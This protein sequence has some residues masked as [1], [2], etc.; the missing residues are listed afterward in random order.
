MI[1]FNDGFQ[2]FW[3]K[4]KTMHFLKAYFEKKEHFIL[5]QVAKSFVRIQKLMETY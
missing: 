5:L 2:A 4:M 1:Y 3:Q